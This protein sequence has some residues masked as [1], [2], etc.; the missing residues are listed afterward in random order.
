MG[1]AAEKQKEFNVH[2]FYYKRATHLRGLKEVMASL[3]LIATIEFKGQHF[4]AYPSAI[5]SPGLDEI[6]KA[7]NTRILFH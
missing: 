1:G 3:P 2:A 5:P 4:R 6:Q 7:P